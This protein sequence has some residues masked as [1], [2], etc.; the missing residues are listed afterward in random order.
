MQNLYH[1]SETG[2]SLMS[3]Q[4]IDNNRGGVSSIQY[5]SF[6]TEAN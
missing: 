6:K 3:L 2:N 1:Y 4:A 5:C